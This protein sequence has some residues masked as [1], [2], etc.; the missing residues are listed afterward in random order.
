MACSL[1]QRSQIVLNSFTFSGSFSLKSSHVLRLPGPGHESAYSPLAGFI[2]GLRIGA[3][4]NLAFFQLPN[5]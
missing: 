1:F 5:D 2:V 3:E 4:S